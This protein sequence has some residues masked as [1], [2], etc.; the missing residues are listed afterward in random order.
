MTP[1]T[2]AQKIEGVNRRAPV[3]SAPVTIEETGL[4]YEQLKQLTLK[5]LYAGELSGGLSETCRSQ[6]AHIVDQLDARNQ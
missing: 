4:S 3:P 5:M 6:R 2:A 1:E